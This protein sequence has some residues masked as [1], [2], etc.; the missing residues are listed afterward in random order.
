VG[1]KGL[2]AVAHGLKTAGDHILVHRVKED[3]LE[4]LAIHAAADLATVDVGGSGD[5]LEDGGVDGLEG[6]GT[7]ALLGSVVLG[8]GGDDGAVGNNDARV[9]ET[10]FKEVDHLGGHFL[11]RSE[12]AERNAN[13]EILVL[14]TVLLLELGLFNGSDEDE[15]E[16][17]LEISLL[18]LEVGEGLGEKLFGFGGLFSVLL[19]NLGFVEHRV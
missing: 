4:L 9:A 17:L 15:A 3:G 12:G 8:A 1:G 19:D 16:V 14:G 11:V 7:G 5:V 18:D 10:F 13:E 6:A 2:V